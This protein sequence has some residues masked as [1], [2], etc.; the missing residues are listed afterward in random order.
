MADQ[1]DIRRTFGATP[2]YVLR[3]SYGQ[4]FA[5]GMPGDLTLEQALDH[6]DTASV[7]LLAR[8]LRRRSADEVNHM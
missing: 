7:N 5:P 8:R 4:G 2:I 6:M 3:Q 1:D